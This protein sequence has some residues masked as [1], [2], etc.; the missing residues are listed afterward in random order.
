M[1]IINPYLVDLV[2]ID[3][4]SEASQRACEERLNNI[5]DN[6]R[7]V[8]IG[9]AVSNGFN[10]TYSSN[11]FIDFSSSISHKKRHMAG[12]RRQTATLCRYKTIYMT[13]VS[14]VVRK[15]THIYIEFSYIKINISPDN[16]TASHAS[17]SY[18]WF[19]KRKQ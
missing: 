3:H 16:S 6:F 1:S 10:R 19:Y 2:S 17:T 11:T 13:V 4:R 14:F 12:V 8:R 5:A 18:L 7:S 15:R 9:D